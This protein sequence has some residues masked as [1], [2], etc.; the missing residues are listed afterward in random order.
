MVLG[1]TLNG[2]EITPSEIKNFEA[3][4][5]TVPHNI[6]DVRRFWVYQA[7]QK[8]YIRLCWFDC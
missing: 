1:V 8:F 5:L 2:Q 7:G 6:K 4:E 3:L